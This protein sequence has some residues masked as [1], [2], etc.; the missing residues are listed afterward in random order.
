MPL[1]ES[2]SATSVII[3]NMMR[4]ARPPPARSSA[5]IWPRSRPGG[6][7]HRAVQ[8]ELIAGARQALT[9]HELQFGTKKPDAGAA[10]VVDMR[11]VDDQAGVDHQLDLLAVFGHAGLVA[12]RRIL[13]LAPGAKPYPLR[14]GGFDFRRGTDIDR[15]RSSVDD[16]GVAG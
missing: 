4:K 8:R 7:Q 3:G 14:I 15:A 11:Q 2:N 12:Q 10:G 1:A 16:D 13:R 9:D 5:R 6:I